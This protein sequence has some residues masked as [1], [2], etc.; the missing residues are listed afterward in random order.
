LGDVFDALFA[1]PHPSA[2]GALAVG[3]QAELAA[4][5]A[6]LEAAQTPRSAAADEEE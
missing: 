4:W 2:R 1:Q 6:A 5:Q 3:S